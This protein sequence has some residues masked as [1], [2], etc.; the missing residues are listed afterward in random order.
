MSG[1]AKQRA[2]RP[3]R[4]PGATSGARI[5]MFTPRPP[6]YRPGVP[7]MA[8]SAAG[9]VGVNQQGVSPFMRLAGQFEA[10]RP[11]AVE[12]FT[13]WMENAIQEVM[14]GGGAR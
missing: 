5:L 13:R 12:I 10:A 2:P 8:P 3:R 1:V 14:T 9:N 6:G 11:L 4:T 7:S